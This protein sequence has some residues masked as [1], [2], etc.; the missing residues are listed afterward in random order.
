MDNKVETILQEIFDPLILGD[1]IK[2]HKLSKS[3]SFNEIHDF[4]ELI[5]LDGTEE[6]YQKFI[7]EHP[8]FLIRTAV[9]TDESILGILAKPPIGNFHLADYAIFSISQGGCHI[10]LVEIEKPSDRLLTK[11]LTPANKLQ[12]ALGQVL[13]WEQYIQQNKQ[14][15]INSCMKLLK[16]SPKYPQKT[17]KGSFIYAAKNRIQS[18]WEGFGGIESCYF[19]YT[20]VIGRWAKLEDNEKRRLVFLNNGYSKQNIRI[21]TYDNLI[22]KAIEGPKYLW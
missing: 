4:A 12:T 14:T 1:E 9:S 8:H 11:K 3:P 6:S 10:H 16:D 20:I 7:S 15:F 19:S 13:D 18:I 17:E 21:R 2:T 5:G 22:R